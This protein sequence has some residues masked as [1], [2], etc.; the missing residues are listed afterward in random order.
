MIRIHKLYSHG[1]DADCDQYFLNDWAVGNSSKSLG[2]NLTSEPSKKLTELF[3]WTCLFIL[4]KYFRRN[5]FIITLISSLLI[6]MHVYMLH[7][8]DN[9]ATSKSLSGGKISLN[10]KGKLS[11][12]NRSFFYFVAGNILTMLYTCT[13][14]IKSDVY[15]LH[16]VAVLN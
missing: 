9:C 8:I 10:K 1:E 15:W 3:L 5:N 2:L 11:N 13:S 12:S 6:S 4:E 7:F 16:K 14:G